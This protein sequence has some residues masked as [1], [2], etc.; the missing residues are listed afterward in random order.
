MQVWLHNQ[1]SSPIEC[2]T[3]HTGSGMVATGCRDGHI[4]ISGMTNGM[5]L[6]DMKAHTDPITGLAFSGNG[7]KLLSSSRDNT[8]VV[9]ELKEQWGGMETD[10][11]GDTVADHLPVSFKALRVFKPME[12]DTISGI[13]CC[14]IDSRG[15]V[16]VAGCLNGKVCI[17]DITSGNTISFIRVSDLEVSSLSFADEGCYFI[18]GSADGCVS[19]IEA[20]KGQ[21]MRHLHGNSSGITNAY[22]VHGSVGKNDL[23][24]AR[25]IS[26]CSRQAI[27]WQ[28]NKT[29]GSVLQSAGW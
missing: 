17:W 12:E 4:V 19:I 29:G 24:E 28:L 1:H 27:T 22:F 15:S 13:S 2:L 16:A 20:I 3:V 23:A 6:A 18:A 7:N 14:G 10:H 9:W 11:E 26:V 8:L 25:L 21:V 5:I